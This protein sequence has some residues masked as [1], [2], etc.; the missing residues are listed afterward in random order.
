MRFS[1]GMNLQEHTEVDTHT[2]LPDHPIFFKMYAK[3]NFVA[4]LLKKAPVCV[5]FKLLH[6]M[7]IF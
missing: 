1:Q 2:G 6:L 3:I 4:T 7:T 5:L